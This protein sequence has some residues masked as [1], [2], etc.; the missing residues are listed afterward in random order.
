MKL[1][2][3]GRRAGEGHIAAGLT[4][5]GRLRSTGSDRR[6]VLGALAEDDATAA[7]DGGVPPEPP[8]KLRYPVLLGAKT[9]ALVVA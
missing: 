3:A 9:S 4:E 7:D 6:V 1:H 2:A 8:T 5:D